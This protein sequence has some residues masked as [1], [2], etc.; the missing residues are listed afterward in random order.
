VEGSTPEPTTT[1]TVAGNAREFGPTV[2]VSFSSVTPLADTTICTLL[3]SLGTSRL[4]VISTMTSPGVAALSRS[5]AKKSTAIA[6]AAQDKS[7]A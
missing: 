6:D 5:H 2:T 1:P 3:R 7:T 4:V